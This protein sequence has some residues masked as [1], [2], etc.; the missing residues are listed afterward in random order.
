MD[1][2]RTPLVA[3]GVLLLAVAAAA[4]DP[5]PATPAPAEKGQQAFRLGLDQLFGIDQEHGHT[6]FD[7]SMR[8]AIWRDDPMVR[9]AVAVDREGAAAR[10]GGLVGYPAPFSSTTL[11]VTMPGPDPRLVFAGPWAADWNDLSAQEKIGRIAESAVYT[12]LIIGI[13]HALR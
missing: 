11:L 7:T 2:V 5:P 3:L 10:R 8:R 6:E 13:L 12:G 1:T 9:L 4:A